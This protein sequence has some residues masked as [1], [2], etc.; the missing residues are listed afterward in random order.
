MISRDAWLTALKDASQQHTDQDALTSI[1]L[2]GL[3][4]KSKSA[5]NVLIRKMLND[6][7]VA[8]TKKSVMDS[9]GRQQVV[10]AYRLVKP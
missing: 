3:Y 1:E 5:I 9:T 6:G 7:T 4:G 2:A 8:L 10:S